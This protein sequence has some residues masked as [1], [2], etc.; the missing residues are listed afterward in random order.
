VKQQTI[1]GKTVTR[2]VSDAEVAAI[3]KQH[4]LTPASPQRTIGGKGQ[5]QQQQQQQQQLQQQQSVSSTY[6][7]HTLLT[8]MGLQVGL[9]ETAYMN[10]GAAAEVM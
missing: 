8:S 4:G 3:L 9:D 10:D 7:T 2:P 5:T 6:S 1:G